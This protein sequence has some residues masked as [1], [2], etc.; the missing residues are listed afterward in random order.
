MTDVSEQPPAVDEI[1]AAIDAVR[2]QI[3]A[4]DTVALNAATAEE[5]RIAKLDAVKAKVALVTDPIN[6][7]MLEATDPREKVALQELLHRK[8]APY[9]LELEEA[10]L[11]FN[12]Q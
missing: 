6:K 4:E 1:Q 12:G 3:A 2:S 10:Y 8:A 7:A 5:E 11:E 9:A